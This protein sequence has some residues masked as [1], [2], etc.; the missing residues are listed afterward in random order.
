MRPIRFQFGEPGLRGRQPAIFLDRDGVINER[1][2]GGYVTRWDEFR[3]LDDF[4]PVLRALG[5]LRA[6]LI[7]ISNQS[8][9]KK[10]LVDRTALRRITSR[11]VE[12]LARQGARITAAY[13]CPHTDAERCG[14]RK[15]K[16]GMLLEAARDYR[17]DLSRSVMIGDSIC[18]VEAA[19]AAGCRGIL[20]DNAGEEL[21]REPR[22]WAETAAP[23]W[24]PIKQA[25]DL[26]GQ[27]AALL[28]RW[29][30]A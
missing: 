25:S 11:F 21:P 19:A 27:V 1:V 29:C 10:G 22:G 8:G 28:G 24:V 4:V 17:I 9:V 14:C 7:V 26:P 16:P 20:L 15:P 6:P 12:A 30:V 18:D 23:T 5:R 2:R 13:Y 3:L